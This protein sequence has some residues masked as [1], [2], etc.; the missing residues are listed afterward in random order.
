MSKVVGRVRLGGWLVG[1]AI[2]A[3]GLHALGL[4]SRAQL[5]AP[6]STTD[7]TARPIELSAIPSPDNPV[8]AVDLEPVRGPR[9][10]GRS[11]S[12]PTG[13]LR[14]VAHYEGNACPGLPILLRGDR[15]VGANLYR[16][17]QTGGPAVELD[18]PTSSTPRLKV[19][20]VASL[21]RF[22]LVVAN[23]SGTD[24]VD[25]TI[26]VVGRT[27]PSG[28]PNLKADAGDDQLGVVGRQITLNGS[29]SQPRDQVGY[30]WVQ[31]A[32]PR[33]RL[34]LED[35]Y[36]YSFVPQAPG[37]YQF[38]L[39]VARGSEMS[40]PDV[41]TV[42]V[43]NP[44]SPFGIQ[45]TPEPPEALHDVARAALGQVPGGLDLAPAL[46]EAFDF[47]ADRMDLYQS[48]AEAYSELSRRLSTLLP[49]DPVRRAVWDERLFAP[50][51]AR[52]IEGMRREALDLRL[53]EAQTTPLT[54]GQRARLAELFRAMSLGFR[55]TRP[56][57]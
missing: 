25:L 26:R 28:D 35:G 23:A 32:G 50:L 27:G 22:A 3:L 2:T 29:R 5:P 48:Y 44:A 11:S 18:N 47:V 49:N 42:S 36:I 39:V 10:N 1:L 31:V 19:P 53:P 33:V 9:L 56:G 30:R 20:E 52:L 34:E 12:S 40:R 45:A 54:S 7:G 51:T 15:S 43:G 8:A 21:L 14:A 17:I 37:I 6:G 16:W 24:V 38:A 46:A 55:A 41:V 13:S 57:S 4:P